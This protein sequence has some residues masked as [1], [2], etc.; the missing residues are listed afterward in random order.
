MPECQCEGIGEHAVEV[1]SDPDVV[2]SDQV[3]HVFDVIRDIGNADLDQLD[4]PAAHV[5][6]ETTVEGAIRQARLDPVEV[7][8]TEER[9]EQIADR[10]LIGVEGGEHGRWHLLPGCDC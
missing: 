8:L 10:T 4:D 7:E 5:E 3:D 9:P 1:G 6:F 2:D